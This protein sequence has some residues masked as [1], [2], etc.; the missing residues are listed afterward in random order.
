MRAV[1]PPDQPRID[2]AQVRFVHECGG[3]QA[4]ADAFPAPLGDPMQLALIDRHHLLE[5]P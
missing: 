5:R 3:L 2:K 4:V 1:L